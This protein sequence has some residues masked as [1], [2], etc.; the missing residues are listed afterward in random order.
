MNTSWDQCA[1]AHKGVYNGRKGKPT[2]ILEAVDDCNGYISNNNSVFPGIYNDV[3][4]WQRSSI[5]QPF[6]S[7]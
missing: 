2:F 5:H 4:V 1:Y 3:N 6:I 7:N